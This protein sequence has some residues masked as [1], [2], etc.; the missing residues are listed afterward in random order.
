M[1]SLPTSTVDRLEAIA[2]GEHIVTIGTFDGVHRG[3]QHL[4][5]RA[6]RRADELGLP[7]LVVTF[8]PVPIQVLRPEL[9]AGR[10][11]T[12][13]E[14]LELLAAMAP[15]EIAVLTFTRDFSRQTP[16]EFM[17]RLVV[18]ARPREVWIGEGFALGRDRAGSIERLREIGQELDYTLVAVPRLEDAGGIISSSAIRACVSNGNVALAMEKLGRPFLVAGEVVRG[19]QVG[20]KIGFP[21][22]NVVPPV[23]LVL[24]PDGIYASLATVPGRAGRLPAMTYIGTRPALNT[25]ERLI[26]THILDFAGDLYGHPIAVE[27]VEHL[28]GDAS[29]PTVEDL[30]A[31]LRAD[32]VAT[33][34]VLAAYSA[35]E[36]G[37]APARA[38][39]DALT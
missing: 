26:E 32:E 19:A 23:D 30:I 9:F 39:V 29:F 7:L 31:Q 12:P 2:A 36:D 5:R 8:E 21:T 27:F 28:R 11:A 1:N 35:P 33:R 25:G 4:L 34:R 6:R 24:P 18:A 15:D 16:E 37:L 20:R 14:K 38:A 22:A 13:A 17:G 10:I 3:H